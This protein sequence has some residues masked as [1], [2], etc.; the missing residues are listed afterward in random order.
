MQAHYAAFNSK[1]FENWQVSVNADYAQ[2]QITS[3]STVLAGGVQEVEYVNVPGV[4]HSSAHL[5]YGFPVGSKKNGNASLSLHGQFGHDISLVNS[6][7]NIAASVGYGGAANINFHL[8]DYLFIDARADIS[9]T[10]S[11][12]SL[13]GSPNAQTRNENYNLNINYRLP[14]AVTIACYYDLQVT[15]SQ[16]ALPAHA[17]SLCNASI[18]RSVFKNYL[19]L[20]V[21]A[22][23]LLN[24]S[25][26]FSQTT[27]VNYVQ[28]QKT[29]LQGR[30]CCLV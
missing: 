26:S 1:T 14:G 3:A 20:R 28:T 23:D 19:E 17:V 29:N 24:S 11:H 18:Y 25:S 16:A 8:K 2:N 9:Q 12:Y 6:V 21:S 4:Y 30:I 13:A 10:I 7:E 22:Y 27:G 15:G 5:T